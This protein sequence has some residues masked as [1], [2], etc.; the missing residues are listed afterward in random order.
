MTKKDDSFDINYSKSENKTF[1]IEHFTKTINKNYK[2]E[3]DSPNY[4]H[5]Q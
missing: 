1:I 5:Y 3:P 4:V 2:I